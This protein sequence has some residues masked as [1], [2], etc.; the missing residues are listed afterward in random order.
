[1][2]ITASTSFCFISFLSTSWERGLATSVSQSRLF[3]HKLQLYSFEWYPTRFWTLWLYHRHDRQPEFDLLIPSWYAAEVTLKLL[4]VLKLE[5]EDLLPNCHISVRKPYNDLFPTSHCS[6]TAA[7]FT[8]GVVWPHF[9]DST[10]LRKSLT[11]PE[12]FVTWLG[13]TFLYLPAEWRTY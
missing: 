1:M 8:E 5:D 6:K 7:S 9:L 3:S 12:S 4:N 13:T 11:L 10:H 2:D